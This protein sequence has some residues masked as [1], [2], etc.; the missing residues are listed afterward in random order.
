MGSYDDI[1]EMSTIDSA[2]LVYITYATFLVGL[3]SLIVV[4]CFV[5][6]VTTGSMRVLD[7]YGEIINGVAYYDSDSDDEEEEWDSETD[8]EEDRE[9]EKPLEDKEFLPI[10]E[11]DSDSETE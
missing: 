2:I 1:R 10:L 9:E 8:D 6:R 11:S 4:D 3:V 5:S 7:R